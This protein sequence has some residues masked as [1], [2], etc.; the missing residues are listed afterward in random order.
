VFSAFIRRARA[1][2]R[3]GSAAVDLCWVAAGRMDAFWEEALNPWDTMAA[4]LI[5]EEAGGRV[6]G[7]DGGPWVPDDGHILASNS[8]LHEAM[9]AVIASVRR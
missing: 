2:R 6:T 7:M 4:A 9:L 5:V 1:V 8:H 3:F